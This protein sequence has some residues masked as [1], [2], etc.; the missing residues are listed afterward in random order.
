MIGA[1]KNGGKWMK[2]I[3]EIGKT[4]MAALGLLSALTA[5]A[6]YGGVNALELSYK[7]GRPTLAAAAYQN[8]S[9]AEFRSLVRKAFESSGFV[10][11]GV[12]EQKEKSTIYEFSFSGDAGAL[13]TMR[14]LVSAEELTDHRK[15]CNPCF[16]RFAEVANA[17]DVGALPWMAQYDLSSRLVPAIDKAYA[18][19]ESSGR[20]FAQPSFKF[21]YKPQWTGEKN[22][23]GN[24]FVDIALPELKE[25]ILRAYSNAGFV[26]G[27]NDDNS[28]DSRTRLNFTFPIDPAGEGGAKYGVGI[29]AQY[30]AQGR[31]HPCE[32]VE[33]YD[34]YQ[35]LPPAGLSGVLNRATL[36]SRF[37]AARNSAHENLRAELTSSLRPR[38]AF[39]GLAK[40]A[41]LGSPTPPMMPVT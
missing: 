41:P 17:S 5:S 19:I 24:S 4:W 3:S 31:C 10:P 25:R 18:A 11:T 23:F 37:S 33:Y 27:E 9:V 22:L 7:V 1:I 2:N 36:E 26:P 6:Q 34:P 35:R 16:L 39:S 21:N 38:S 14:I 32:I 8:I 12:K 30:D 29:L 13:P 20:P 40:V 28:K 15:R